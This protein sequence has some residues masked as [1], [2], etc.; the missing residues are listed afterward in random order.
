MPNHSMIQHLYRDFVVEQDWRWSGAHYRRTADDWLANY[1]AHGSQIEAI[2]ADVY[3]ANTALWKRR[4]RLFFFAT[5]GLFGAR[6]G[7]AWGVSHYRA[8]PR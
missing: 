1:D 8:R 3:G 7:E 6:S 2:L 5:S 4:W